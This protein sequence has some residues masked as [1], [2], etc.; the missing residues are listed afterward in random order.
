MEPTREELD[1]LAYWRGGVDQKAKEDTERDK[2]QLVINEDVD[3]ALNE[4]LNKLGS[5]ETK[6]KIYSALG[7]AFGSAAFVLVSQYIGSL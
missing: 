5:I 2:R 6:I 4:L 3:R 1:R 7:G